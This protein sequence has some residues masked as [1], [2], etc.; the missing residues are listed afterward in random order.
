MDIRAILTLKSSGL[1]ID[2][3]KLV[4]HVNTSTDSADTKYPAVESV[5]ELNKDKDAA[6]KNYYLIEKQRV[7]STLVQYIVGLGT[8]NGSIEKED[9]IT[10]TS[11]NYN[12]QF[13]FDRLAKNSNIGNDV[14][15]EYTIYGI[16][17]RNAQESDWINV[18]P[19]VPA[20]QISAEKLKEL[21]RVNRNITGIRYSAEEAPADAMDLGVADEKMPAKFEGNDLVFYTTAE[22]IKLVGDTY[23]LFKDCANLSDISALSKWDISDAIYTAW[24][25]SNCRKL[26]D[27]TPIKDWDVSNIKDMGAFFNGCTSL[28]DIS[29]LANWNTKSNT[30]LEKTFR[31]CAIKNVDALANWDVSNLSYKCDL[32]FTFD[33]CENLTDISGL[34][35][36]KTPK[37]KNMRNMLSNCPNLSDVSVLNNWTFPE[38]TAY[39]GI[40]D[41]TAV[42]EYPAWYN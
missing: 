41:G 12:M 32:E 24:M 27:L 13:Y 1:N 34:K 14:T 2:D 6:D 10:K 31:Y 11:D 30:T 21:V 18:T 40:F 29:P 17:H 36:W 28:E 20:T 19:I 25:F 8:L 4:D 7:N 37:I 26:T 39:G 42:T 15:L 33:G 9:G 16:Q 35:N 23:E 22:R 38:D 5:E 3:Y